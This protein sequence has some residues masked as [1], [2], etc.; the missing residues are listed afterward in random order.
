[1]ADE[2]F[3]L[4][5]ACQL[6]AGDFL[7]LYGDRYADPDCDP[8]KL[9]EF[10]YVRVDDVVRETEETVRVDFVD[11]DSVGFPPDYMV[12]AECNGRAQFWK[13]RQFGPVDCLGNPAGFVVCRGGEGQY[14]EAPGGRFFANIYEPGK[15]PREMHDAAQAYCD[16]LNGQIVSK[17]SGGSDAP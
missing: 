16:R 1:M 6:R 14:E 4:V 15:G 13:V 17:I 5:P 9:F 2:K 11:E 12:L 8:M 10:E 3:T 7:D